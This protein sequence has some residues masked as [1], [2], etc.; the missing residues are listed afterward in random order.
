MYALLKV[1]S[2]IGA[3]GGKG[4]NYPSF[5]IFACR[6]PR[7]YIQGQK[8]PYLQTLIN[9]DIEPTFKL[10]N[11]INHNFEYIMSKINPHQLKLSE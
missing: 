7:R 5:R 1:T 8:K 3:Y 2:G 10:L 4:D 9:D 11:W 6:V